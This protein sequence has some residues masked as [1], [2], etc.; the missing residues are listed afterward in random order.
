MKAILKAWRIFR[1]WLRCLWE[2]KKVPRILEG[3]PYS[4]NYM[5]KYWNPALRSID[6]QVND[7]NHC[8]GN[9]RNLRDRAV[10]LLLFDRRIVVA[11]RR[12]CRFA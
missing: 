10:E 11:K 12:A 6:K 4:R 5:R 1:W 3:A 7:W 8:A 2:G 9:V